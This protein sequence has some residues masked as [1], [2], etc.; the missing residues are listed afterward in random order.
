M[1]LGSVRRSVFRHLSLCRI[2]LAQLTLPCSVLVVCLISSSF[3]VLLFLLSLLYLTQACCYYKPP[4]SLSISHHSLFFLLCPDPWP[5][6]DLFLVRPVLYLVPG[7][8]L[9][10]A[11]HRRRARTD[12]HYRRCFPFCPALR[13]GF[14]AFFVCC[15]VLALSSGYYI[16]RG[17]FFALCATTSQS[18]RCALSG[19]RHMNCTLPTRTPT[20]K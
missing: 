7:A 10:D 14:S 9:A 12:S 18:L 4:R 5:G 13:P 2:S 3:S 6:T 1:S 11:G 20:Q 17:V 19:D 15:T 16:I 8:W